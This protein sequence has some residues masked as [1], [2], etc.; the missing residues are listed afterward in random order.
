VVEEELDEHR[1]DRVGVLAQLLDDVER[2]VGAGAARV[3]RRRSVAFNCGI[4]G[5]G[6]FV[7]GA[8]AEAGVNAGRLGRSR[9]RPALTAI[10]AVNAGRRVEIPD[11]PALTGGPGASSMPPST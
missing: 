9:S 6:P 7:V 8:S 10:Y 1:G 4:E 11:R 3:N 2:D 5:E